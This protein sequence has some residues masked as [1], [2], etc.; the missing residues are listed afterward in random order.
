MW[1][2][3]LG[4]SHLTGD[5]QYDTKISEALYWQKSAL[6][7]FMPPNQTRTLANDDQSCWGL[8]AMTAAEVG[9]PKAKDKEWIEY[10]TNVWESQAVRSDFEQ[11]ANGTCG[12][13][14][15][16]QI[17]SFNL[18]YSYKN[19]WSNGNF[20]LL[21]ARLAKFTGNSTF[22]QYADKSYQWASNLGLVTDSFEVFAGTEIRDGA[23]KNR[24][25]LQFSAVHGIYTEG[26][27][28]MYNMVSNLVLLQHTFTNRWI[29]WRCTKLDQ[30][31][32]RLRKCFQNFPVF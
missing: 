32:Q 1:N 4:Y 7:N 19:T 17:F 6:D 25:R 21:S 16:W 29:D 20:F 3:L 27:A 15:R 26:A 10:A 9:L 23:C 5:K 11:Q 8:A 31:C 13:G 12:R 2:A 22:A 30:G 14:L 18:G 28:L 24:D